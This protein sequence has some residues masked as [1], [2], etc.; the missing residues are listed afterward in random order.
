MKKIVFI[1]IISFVTASVNA[2]LSHTK[3]KGAIKGDNPQGAMLKFGKDT[4]IL[5]AAKDG[6]VIETMKYSVK[7]GVLTMIKISGQSDCDNK[8]Y[9]NYKFVIKDGMLNMT[10]TSDNCYDRSSALDKTVWKK[11]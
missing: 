7:E 8:T 2:Q 3:W 1:L 9:G 6:S 11:G 10:V 5:Y 4:L